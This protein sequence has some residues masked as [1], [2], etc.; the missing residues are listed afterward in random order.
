MPSSR[1]QL[2]T[3]D[4]TFFL[5]MCVSL[6]FTSLLDTEDHAC[7]AAT[8]QPASYFPQFMA[9][10]PDQRHPDRP[11][12]LNV[13]NILA[14]GFSVLQIKALQP[15]AHRLTSCVRTIETCRQALETRSHAI[16]YQFW[17]RWSI[18]IVLRRG[19]HARG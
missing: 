12:E 9:Q 2:S 19:C 11:G 8:C 14:D 7:N 3:D 16:Q 15:F 17:Y 1:S 5:F 4:P 6:S 18:P 10:R 13:F